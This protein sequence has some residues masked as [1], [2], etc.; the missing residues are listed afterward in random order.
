MS[1]NRWFN[2][3][4]QRNKSK[5]KQMRPQKN[6]EASIPQK[7]QWLEKNQQT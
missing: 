4:D 7:K 3:I 5:D 6:R 2:A 1:W